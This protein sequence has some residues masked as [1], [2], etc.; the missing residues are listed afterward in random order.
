MTETPIWEQDAAAEE[1]QRLVD[2]ILIRL[3]RSST[4]LR[5]QYQLNK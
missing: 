3:G 5:Y 2:D 4:P 1:Q